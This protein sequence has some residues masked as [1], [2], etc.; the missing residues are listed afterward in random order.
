MSSSPAGRHW[1]WGIAIGLLIVVLINVLFAYVAIAGADP[2][3]PS[4]RT[5]A[6]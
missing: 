3:V 5:E 4:Y 1:P 2:V 6:R